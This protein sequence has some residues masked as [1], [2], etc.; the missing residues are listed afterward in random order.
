MMYSNPK[1]SQP[2]QVL[3]CLFCSFSIFFSSCSKSKQKEVPPPGQVF[4]D[5]QYGTGLTDENRQ[6]VLNLDIYMPAHAGANRKYPLFLMIHGGGFK[7]GDKQEMASHCSLLADSGYIGVSINYRLGW[8]GGGDT[9]KCEGDTLAEYSSL[10]RAVQDANAALRFLVSKQQEYHIDTSRIY[11]GGGSVGGT[12]A[13]YTHYVPASKATG[14][15]PDESKRLGQLNEG[16][17]PIRDSFTIKG[18][19]NLWGGMGDSTLI[20]RANAVPTIFFHGTADPLSPYDIGREFSCAVYPV[21]LGSAC[22]SRQLA[23]YGVPYQL[24]LKK[25]AAHAPAAFH[26]PVTIPLATAFFNKLNK[27]EHPADK[28]VME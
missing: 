19:L 27:G 15:L 10:Y 28:A 22:L 5:V 6:Q 3:F 4:K 26:A 2:A 13:M 11:I 12:I 14:L 17:N 9:R 8:S 16:D 25:E 1:Y 23:R 20:T 24:Y 21:A 18:I 7:E